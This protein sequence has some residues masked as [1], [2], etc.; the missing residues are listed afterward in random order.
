MKLGRAAA[1]HR[2]RT[3]SEPTHDIALTGYEPGAPGAASR[4]AAVTSTIS[5]N[6]IGADPPLRTA[7]RKAFTSSAWPFS[8]RSCGRL[9]T[10]VQPEALS[11]R[12]LS[13]T[14]TRPPA[15]TVILSLGK[16]LD[17]LE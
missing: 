2:T 16:R 15:R 5:S 9:R 12:K 8:W 11:R 13:L 14:R 17:P 4:V 7:S 1:T 3:G 10:P 6:G